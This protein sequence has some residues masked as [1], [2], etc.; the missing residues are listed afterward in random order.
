MSDL[1]LSC[2]RD[3][4][5]RCGRSTEPIASGRNVRG[6]RAL[7][8]LR[9]K[10]VRCDLDAI[11]VEHPSST[12]TGDGLGAPTAAIA[13]QAGVSTGTVFVHF[14]TK[15]LL[16]NELYVEL[17]REMAH[18]ATDA[19]PADATPREQL[20]HRWDQWIAWSTSEPQKRRALAHLGVAEVL[21]EDSR[22]AVEQA[23][24]DIARR[25]RTIVEAGPLRDA[26]LGFALALMSSMTDT[27]IDDLVRRPDPTGSR[28]ALAFDAMWRALAG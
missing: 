2:R 25:V 18:V 14:E 3:R 21:T 15:S 13:A 5:L 24:E 22:T 11:E 10:V 9:S 28:S 12:E 26:P 20:R 7:P 1:F 17:K 23:Y 16:V 6:R 8:A 4:L 19:L 27:T